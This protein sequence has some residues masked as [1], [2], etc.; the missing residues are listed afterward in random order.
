M[1]TNDYVPFATG[2]GANVES[3]A[4]WA[5]DA[6]RLT[7]FVTGT[8]PSTKFN[9]A[10]RQASETAAMIGQFINTKGNL[11]AN[12]DGNITTLMNSFIAESP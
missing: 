5:A 8:A 4:S 12:D 9:T 1:P 6:T 2:G 11:N 10:L 3:P 7:G